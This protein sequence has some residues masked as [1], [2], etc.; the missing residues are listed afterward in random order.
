MPCKFPIHGWRSR[1]RNETGKRS[2]VYRLQKALYDQRAV[3][4]CGQCTDCRLNKSREWA[5]RCVHEASLWDANCIATLTY[6]PEHLP[7]HGS[8]RPEDAVL[9][10]KRLRERERY[11]FGKLNQRQP[12]QEG[13]DL[14][15][16]DIRSFGCAEYGEE[17]QRPHYHIIL[18]NHHFN[19]RDPITPGYYDSQELTDIWGMG[20]TQLMDLTFESAAYVS[21]YVMKKLT[22]PRKQEYG[23][24]LPEQPVCISRMPGI[25]RQW[26]EHWKEEIYKQDTVYRNKQTGERI[27]MQPPKYYDKRM[28]IDNPQKINKIKS[29]RKKQNQ[30][31]I[32]AIE[33]EISQGN[34][35][36]ALDGFG[37]RQRA[38][39]D[40][41]DASIRQLKRKYE[42]ET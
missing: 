21:R 22:G 17:G 20:R 27:P 7:E 1:D 33:N 11:K 25:G 40:C 5:I 24:R 9:F 42:N 3:V 8:I 15:A 39:L 28:E 12:D 18:F 19:D 36:N 26:Y 10:M 37:S 13:P 41:Q 6:K 23:K 14:L 31:K 35:T 32:I 29:I 34:Y 38:Y 30:Q 2:I 4:P 16:S